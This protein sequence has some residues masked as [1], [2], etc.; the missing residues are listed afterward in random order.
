MCAYVKNT[1]LR[2]RYDVT[3]WV[4]KEWRDAGI[5]G[6]GRNASDEAVVC[7][8]LNLKEPIEPQPKP[9]VVAS[10]RPSVSIA[11]AA[12]ILRITAKSLVRY[13]QEGRY[14]GP[15]GRVWESELP[16]DEPPSMTVAEAATEWGCSEKMIYNWKHAGV[17]NGPRGRIWTNEEK[18]TKGHYRGKKVRKPGTT[19]M[20]TRNV[21]G[22]RVSHSASPDFRP[23]RD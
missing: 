7:R 1:V 9:A 17:I 5:E 14:S 10:E 8:L 11:E 3:P 20:P 12:R 15:V 22:Y 21:S 6:I 13:K 23:F 19:E 18:P 4:M 16:L 2:E